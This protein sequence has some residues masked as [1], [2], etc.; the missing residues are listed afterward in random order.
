MW[1][2]GGRVANTSDNV[3]T[4]DILKLDPTTETIPIVGHLI[5]AREFAG[6][7]PFNDNSIEV[8]GGANWKDTATGPP[9]AIAISSIERITPVGVASKIGDMPMPKMTFTPVMLQ[10][11]RSLLVGGSD[12]NG[13]AIDT[14]Y[15]FDETT[16]ISGVT[17]NMV[18]TRRWYAITPLGTGR[19]LIVGGEDGWGNGSKTAEIFEP[20]VNIYIVTPKITVAPGEFLQLSAEHSSG[21]VTWTAKYGV[22]ISDGGYTAP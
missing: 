12:L 21:T 5:Q 16:H 20:D 18:E 14:Q 2:V 17:G 8:Y 4:D 6:I 9:M 13:L 3:T 15:V 10:N 22:V 1:I 19:V 11:G 7:L